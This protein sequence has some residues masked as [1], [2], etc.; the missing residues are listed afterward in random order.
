MT[1]GLPH[2]VGPCTGT[3]P[4][5]PPRRAVAWDHGRHPGETFLGGSKDFLPGGAAGASGHG[6]RVPDGRVSGDERRVRTLRRGEGVRHRSR[7]DA[8]PRGLPGDRSVLLVSGPWSAG[9]RRGR[10]RST[11]LAPGART[12]RARAG[13]VRRGR[14]ARSRGAPPV[15]HAAWA[16]MALPT[17]TEWEFAARDV[18]K[19]ATY[20]WGDEFMPRP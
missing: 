8:R 4:I 15:V 9:R 7:A 3:S 18:L 20:L 1:G 14:G 11:P 6:G 10:S 5:P 19:G 17:G 12:Y 2:L 16:G 13:G